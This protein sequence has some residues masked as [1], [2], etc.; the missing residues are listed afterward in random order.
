M[1]A[2]E[3]YKQQLEMPEWKAKRRT[4]YARDGHACVDCGE[5]GVTIHCHHLHYVAGKLPWEYHSDYLVTVCK[6]CHDKRHRSKLITFASE[7]EVESWYIFAQLEAEMIEEEL[8]KRDER[9]RWLEDRGAEFD[10]E[11]RYWGFIDR[12]GRPRFYDED[13]NPL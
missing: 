9:I 4:I 11:N 1:N 3:W 10:S 13:G 7:E 12:Q 8:A 6:E 5:D 2:K